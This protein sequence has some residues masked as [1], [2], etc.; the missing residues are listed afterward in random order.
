MIRTL[1]RRNVH[2]QKNAAAAAVHGAASGSSATN[3]GGALTVEALDKQLVQARKAISLL[4]DR[5]GALSKRVDEHD[6]AVATAEAAARSADSARGDIDSVMSDV[7]R[8]SGM[9]TS[10]TD[11]VATLEAARALPQSAAPTEQPAH[12]QPTGSGETHAATEGSPPLS[13]GDARWQRMEARLAALEGGSGGSTAGNRGARGA[14]STQ[15]KVE[16]QRA[17]AVADVD[18]DGETIVS[19]CRVVVS[20]FAHGTKLAALRL[21]L[22]A[23][24]PVLNFLVRRTVSRDSRSADGGLTQVAIVTFGTAAAAVRAVENLDGM[25]LNNETLRIRPCKPADLEDLDLKPAVEPI[26]DIA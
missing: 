15:S 8:L 4:V 24:G 7:A 20:G 9:L 5:T 10:L 19:T 1:L 25:L 22:E 12:Q 2:R 11:R 26:T 3:G 18:V 21:R 13:D 17:D 23:A 6:G 16:L 14:I